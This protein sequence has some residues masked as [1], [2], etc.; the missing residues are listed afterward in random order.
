MQTFLFFFIPHTNEEY[1][2]ARVERKTGKGYLG[3]TVDSNP[4]ITLED[5]LLR[6]DLTINSMAIEVKGLFD[7]SFKDGNIIDPY[8]GLKDIDE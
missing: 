5:D 3:F 1:A 7:S 2:L 6:R 4:N 8:K